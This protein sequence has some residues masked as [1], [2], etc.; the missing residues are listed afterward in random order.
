MAIKVGINGFGRIGRTVFK[1][2]VKNA[3]FEVVGINDITDARTLAHLLKYDS[4]FGVLDAEVKATDDAIIVNGKAY[5]VTAITDPAQL[6]WK[7]LGAEI[8]VESTGKF[9]KKDDCLKHVQAGAKKVLL[10]V[11][12]KDEVDAIIVMGVNDET[13]K[14][15]DV[16]VSNASCTTNCLAPV[17]K[18]LHKNFGIVRGF[19]TT[20]HAYTNDQ[21][22]LD[23]PHKDLRRARAAANAIIPTTTGAARA[24]GKVLPELKGKLDGFAM[25]VPVIDGSVVDLVAELEKK[26]TKEDINKAIKEASETY[27]KGILA[28]TEDPIV[29]CDVIG[30]PN[31]SI[32]DAQSTM[33]MGD[34]FVKVVSWYDNEFGYSNRCV[35]LIKLMAK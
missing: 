6:P 32:F 27:L 10:T 16:V 5:K 17:A 1:L 4:V 19:M 3:D 29:S 22:V 7:D 25:R 35:D 31:S 8:I 11:P 28:Y 24:V 26:A 13:L 20:V 2:L 23:M 21:R 33:V 14:S 30:N 34:N 15:T 9:T 12:P 18:V